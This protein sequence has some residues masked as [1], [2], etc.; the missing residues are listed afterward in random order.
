DGARTRR[1]VARA[2]PRAR[3]RGGDEAR[4]RLGLG[5]RAHGGGRAGRA[6]DRELAPGEDGGLRG[7][8]ELGP[9][10][11]DRRRGP[12]AAAPRARPGVELAGVTVCRHG[13]A[14]G[15]AAVA[16]AAARL[17]RAREVEI[18]VDLGAG[19]AAARVWTCDLSYDY[20]RINAEYT[21]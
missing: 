9:H 11:P 21:T 15:P 4:H 20:V 18:R 12:R 17:R 8:P 7:R 2:R 10:P 5:G 13:A 14:R 3:R 1:G 16:R 19:R 6:P